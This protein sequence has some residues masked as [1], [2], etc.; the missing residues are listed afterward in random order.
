MSEI[1]DDEKKAISCK[2]DL[3][4]ES[5]VEKKSIIINLKI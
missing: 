2:V 3:I 5:G 4:G 1:E